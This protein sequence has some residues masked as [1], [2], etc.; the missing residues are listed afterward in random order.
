MLTHV[1][2]EKFKRSE[3][4]SRGGTPIMA[5]LFSEHIIMI[6]IQR[7]SQCTPD[8]PTHRNLSIH[9]D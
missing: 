4:S 3:K 9:W 1:P 6:V 7:G 5:S 8:W 2:R